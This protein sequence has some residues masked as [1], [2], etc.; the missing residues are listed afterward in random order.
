M[1][2][3]IIT[4]ALGF[5]FLLTIFNTESLAQERPV[6]LWIHGEYVETDVNPILENGRTL[7]PVRVIS[8]TL[9]YNVDWDE[10]LFT[11]TVSDF[12][13][14]RDN[15]NKLFILTINNKTIVD[16]DVEKVN[17][18]FLENPT[19]EK[20]NAVM[21]ESAKPI[22]IDVAPKLVEK[23]TFVPV[24]VVAE[25]LGEKVN[26]DLENWTVVIGEDYKGQ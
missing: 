9:G 12:N 18:L 11:V 23:R 21:T 22:E 4:I 7:V 15:F 5:I 1:K 25:L 14:T 8:E 20:L 24:R 2:K 17:R 13:E 3:R 16:Y 10:E 19:D 6:K 26:W